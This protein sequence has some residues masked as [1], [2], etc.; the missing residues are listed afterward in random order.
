MLYA[1]NIKNIILR[2]TYTFCAYSCFWISDAAQTV[3]R[4]SV[5]KLSRF[6]LVHV[7]WPDAS[8][9]FEYADWAQF[10]NEVSGSNISI[11]SVLFRFV[12]PWTEFVELATSFWTHKPKCWTCFLC[13]CVCA[14][15]TLPSSA[16]HRSWDAVH[17]FWH[18]AQRSWV[19]RPIM[20]EPN[21]QHVPLQVSVSVY[22]SCSAYKA[23]TWNYVV[24]FA[25]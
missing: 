10:C 18:L 3:I 22:L 5:F 15:H 14:D 13:V 21:I 2:R 19:W 25:F 1:F 17:S 6:C 8:Q 4:T 16:P 9:M 24:R 12:N 7:T 20:V 11:L 23:D